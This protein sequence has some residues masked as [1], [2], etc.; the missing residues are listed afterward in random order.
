MSGKAAATRLNILHQAFN[1][2]Y[3]NG[4]RT[5]SIDEIIASTKVT[6]GAFFYHFKNK[7]EMG[8]AMINE[9]LY[10]GMKKAITEKLENAENPKKAIYSM[11]KSILLDDPFFDVRY[12]CPAI[13]LI[14]E[15][16]TYNN[17]FTEALAQLSIE[18]KNA[19][20]NCFN[21][22]KDAGIIAKNVNADEVSI[23][24]LSGYGGI[25]NMGKIFG[26]P[27]YISYLK[28]LK[29]YLDKL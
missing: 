19:I 27:S 1:I 23:F 24:I 18:W 10:P 6:K 28:E 11:M 14:E 8:L 17:T 5:T 12:G 7:D 20:T 13:N 26:K 22:G 9:M 4:Y 16:A 25:R 29:K 3:H 2:V 21:K 15:L